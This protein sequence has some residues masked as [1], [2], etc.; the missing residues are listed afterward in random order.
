MLATKRKKMKI[1]RKK[2]KIKKDECMF[3]ENRNA[4]VQA[5]AG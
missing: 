4:D 3:F 2:M 5:I 1:K